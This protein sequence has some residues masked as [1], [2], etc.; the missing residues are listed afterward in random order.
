V[1]MKLSKS[2][3]NKTERKTELLDSPPHPLFQSVI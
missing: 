3:S 1:D 2:D